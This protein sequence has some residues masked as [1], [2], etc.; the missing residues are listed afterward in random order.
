[1]VGGLTLPNQT[2]RVKAIVLM[3]ANR[4]DRVLAIASVM[5]AVGNRDPS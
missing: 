5:Y 1:V 3:F 2:P 4:A